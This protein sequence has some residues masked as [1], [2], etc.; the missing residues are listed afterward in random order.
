MRLTSLVMAIALLLA[1][2]KKTDAPQTT[3]PGPTSGPPGPKDTGDGQA[4][5][6]NLTAPECEAQG[7]KVVGDIGDGA[8]HR[9][10]YKCESGS[11]PVGTIVP[12]AGGP[13]AIEGA[14]CCK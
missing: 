11:P 9:P 5:R 10:D 2:E 7:G 12:D 1:C 6:P 3:T 8:I 4:E 13:T 14:V